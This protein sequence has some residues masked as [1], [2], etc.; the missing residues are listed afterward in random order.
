[1]RRSA[2]REQLLAAAEYDRHCKGAPRINEVISEQRVHKFG[3]SCRNRFTSV[4]SR[5]R[6]EPCQLVSTTP[7][8][9]TTYFLIFLN[10]VAIRPATAA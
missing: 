9:D 6:T 1:V 10:S 7:E 2:V 8:L 4:M 3:P 5:S